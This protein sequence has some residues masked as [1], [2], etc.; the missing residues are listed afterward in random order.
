M[1]PINTIVAKVKAVVDKIKGFFPIKLGKLM[2]FS[3]PRI[4][5]GTTSKTIGGKSVQV[6]SFSLSWASHALGGIFSRRTLM[7]SGN[8]IHEF[9]EAGPEAIVPLDP[10]WKRLEQMSSTNSTNVVININGA[11]KDPR[12]I[13]EEVKRVLVRETNQRRLAWQ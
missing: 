7:A 12:E 13:A 3:L 4:S 10:F 5:I 2:N 1:A 9:G 11:N 8:T 6:P